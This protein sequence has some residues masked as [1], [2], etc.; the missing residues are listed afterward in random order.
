MHTNPLPRPPLPLR[1]EKALGSVGAVGGGRTGAE[2]SLS[3]RS[4]SSRV[5]AKSS[6]FSCGCLLVCSREKGIVNCVVGYWCLVVGM[7]KFNDVL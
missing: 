2:I 7:I 5:W 6:M 4:S 3:K 1:F